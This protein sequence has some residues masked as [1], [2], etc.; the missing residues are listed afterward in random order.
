MKLLTREDIPDDAITVSPS[1]ITLY[2]RCPYK[3]YLSKREGKTEFVV[4]TEKMS[5]GTVFHKLL[6]YYYK[7]YLGGPIGLLNSDEL[8]LMM[9]EVC[10]EN[11]W[12]DYDTQLRF[13]NAYTIFITYMNWALRNEKLIPLGA[14]VDTF[15]PTGLRSTF[16]TGRRPI[17]LHGILDLIA[18][19]NGR[20]GVVDHK[21]HTRRPWTAESILF[22]TQCLFY[23]LLLSLQDVPV[24]W[25][26]ISTIDMHLPKKDVHESLQRE[27][28]F[29]RFK[30][31]QTQVNLERYT[32]ELFKTIKQMW[33]IPGMDF[34]R[35]LDRYCSGCGFSEICGMHL[36]GYDIDEL[37]ESKYTPTTLQAKEFDASELLDADSGG[38]NPDAYPVLND[39]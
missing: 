5:L 16:Q 12:T 6:E 31:K 9:E 35:R 20:V 14:E 29:E 27:E 28:R 10:A 30:I 7:K 33:C 2:Q 26:M 8:A 39:D 17:Y 19:Q 1:Q 13:F 23:P 3:W 15:A 32:E 25:A 36:R 22:D 37:I 38:A 18:E 24:D 4:V 34:I 11:G 21:T